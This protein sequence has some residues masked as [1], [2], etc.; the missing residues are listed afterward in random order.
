MFALFAILKFLGNGCEA[1][2]NLSAL[3][4]RFQSQPPGLSH[5]SC[6]CADTAAVV[7]VA[8]GRQARASAA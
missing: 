5:S 2:L 4:R 8:S 3:V 7:E 1:F 6:A